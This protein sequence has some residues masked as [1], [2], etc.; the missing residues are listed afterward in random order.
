MRGST[1]YLLKQGLYSELAIPVLWLRKSSYGT[2]NLEFRVFRC[3]LHF[4]IFKSTIPISQG[5]IKRCRLSW[6]TNSALVLYM[7]PN[8][9][10]GG[11]GASANENSCAHGAQR[12]FGDLT[13]YLTYAI[14]CLDGA[15]SMH[16]GC[17]SS[18]WSA[19]TMAM[20]RSATC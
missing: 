18:T 16:D 13:P 9:G 1:S 8:A 14:F 11:C 2:V 10:G 12:N 7:S 20:R 6:L 19:K 17:G 4:T 15:T 3:F 5:V